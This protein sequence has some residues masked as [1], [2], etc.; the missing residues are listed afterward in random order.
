MDK[1]LSYIMLARKAG[2][3]SLGYENTRHEI[4]KG[5]VKL[6]LFTPDLSEKKKQSFKR[7][8]E[9]WEI[10]TLDIE[11]NLDTIEFYIGKRCGIIGI[12][13]GGFSKVIL[14]ITL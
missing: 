12:R 3:L 9:E 5:N 7:F 4:F 6:V 8:C 13:D 14:S 2:K 11:H 1:I 10:K